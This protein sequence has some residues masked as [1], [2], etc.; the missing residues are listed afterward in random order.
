M[1]VPRSRR[2]LVRAALTGSL[3]LITATVLR[4]NLYADP[5]PVRHPQGSA[6]AFIALKTLEDR[7][8]ATGDV[9]QIVHRDEV[10]SHVSFRFGD[11]S[12]D[13]ETTVFTHLASSA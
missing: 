4:G 13:D 2:S 12:M 7:R 10:T 1:S 11:G 8:I 5:I 3:L 9:I 6:H